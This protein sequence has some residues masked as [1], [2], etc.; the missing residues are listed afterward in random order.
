MSTVDSVNSSLYFSATALASKNVS[1]KDQDIKT[2]K[3]KKK[4]SFEKK[5]FSPC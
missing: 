3:A 1:Q 4:D 5:D 2:E